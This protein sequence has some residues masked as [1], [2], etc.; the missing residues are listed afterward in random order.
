MSG[1]DTDV[2][3]LPKPSAGVPELGGTERLAPG[4]AALA[5]QYRLGDDR[6][7]GRRASSA[8]ARSGV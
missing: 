8:A 5:E 1:S 7:A 3:Y 2:Q 6:R 4:L